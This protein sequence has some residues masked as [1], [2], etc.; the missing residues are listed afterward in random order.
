MPNGETCQ[1]M[2]DDVVVYDEGDPRLY[3][4]IV[5]N[6]ADPFDRMD[7]ANKACNRVLKGSRKLYKS[8]ADK[9]DKICDLPVVFNPRL[10][11]AIARCCCGYNKKTGKLRPVK[12]DWST[13][14]DM[15]DGLKYS[16]L[17][18]EYCHA[19]R[20]AV[21]GK[22]YLMEK[23]HG[24]E[25]QELMVASGEIPAATCKDERLVRAKYRRKGQAERVPPPRKPKP[26][27]APKPAPKPKPKPKPKPTPK[28][29]PP[30]KPK[31]KPKPRKPKPA[32]PPVGEYGSWTVGKLEAE[33]DRVTLEL[34]GE[35][36]PADRRTYRQRYND[37]YD[38]LVRRGVY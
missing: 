13:N 9:A 3:E 1:L 38:E 27:P 25:W 16:I 11:R 37:M 17:V 31:P 8:E 6:P 24:L 21:S 20:C 19:A 35:L 34:D 4:G 14:F 7:L 26:K 36:S 33:L 28:P 29:K 10:T 5:P 15:P 23:A 30:P 18:H 32:P 12:I 2:D 22:D